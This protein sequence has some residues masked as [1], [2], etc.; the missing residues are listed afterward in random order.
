MNPTLQKIREAKDTRT[1]TVMVDEW[2]VELILIEPVRKVIRDMQ[3]KYMK[4][5]P[6]TG[7]PVEGSDADKF[8]MAMLVEMVYTPDGKKV[9]VDE[10][11]EPSI[12][13]AEEVLDKK[14]SR[15]LTKLIEQCGD[16]V[17]LP[18]KEDVENAEGN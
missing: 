2:G 9:F 7:E 1:V 16:L 14:S 12:A 15:V 13:V 5:D 10:N 18:T 6:A 3:E 17:R 11:G 4:L 8:G